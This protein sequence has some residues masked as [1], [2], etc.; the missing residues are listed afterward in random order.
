MAARW[1]SPSPLASVWLF[2][3]LDAPLPQ[4]LPVILFADDLPLVALALITRTQLH[5]HFLA[6][7]RPPSWLGW[8][9]LH[10]FCYKPTNLFRTD[11]SVR[12]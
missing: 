3:N 10:G 2:L 11:R 4:M 8:L 6:Q 1:L 12:P 5:I 7:L 9:P